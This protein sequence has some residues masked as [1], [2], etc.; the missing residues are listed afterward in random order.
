MKNRDCR[1]FKKVI[2]K[3]DEILEENS[4]ACRNKDGNW[5]II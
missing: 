2:K 3:D 4:T 5:E 1:D